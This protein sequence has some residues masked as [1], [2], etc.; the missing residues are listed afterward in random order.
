MPPSTSVKSVLPSS[1][2]SLLLQAPLSAISVRF[3]P[4]PW[5]TSSMRSAGSTPDTCD[6][7]IEHSRETGSRVVRS[8][9]TM[10]SFFCVSQQISDAA[11]HA[12]TARIVRRQQTH[13]R[14]SCLRW[15]T[16]PDA[17]DIGI[18]IRAA[19]FAPA[20]VRVLHHAQPFGGLL[21]IGLVVIDANGLQSAQNQ[22][23]SV[24]VVHAPASEPGAVR[25]LLIAYKLEC[26][27]CTAG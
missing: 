15:R 20:A 10:P 24:D 18:I 14:P 3:P 17:F 2:L 8:H 23:G 12:I 13:D 19:R 16:R 4:S 5:R 9:P 7:K 26:A 21:N 27:F 22:H 25:L 6:T 1:C 11:R